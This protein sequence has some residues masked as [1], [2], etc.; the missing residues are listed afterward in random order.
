MDVEVPGVPGKVRT[1]FI[2]PQFKGTD[3][4]GRS[5]P[6]LLIHGFDSSALEWRRTFPR[7]AEH[8]DVYAVDV[9][10]CASDC[11]HLTCR[12]AGSA[13]DTAALPSIL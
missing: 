13:S 2:G 8:A 1:A 10:G 5:P 4:K 3:T 7:L 11:P 6:I 9:F 12:Q